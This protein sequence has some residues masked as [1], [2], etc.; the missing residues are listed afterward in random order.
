MDAR[1]VAMELHRDNARLPVAPLEPSPVKPRKRGG[2][3]PQKA[4][5]PHPYTRAQLDSRTHAAKIWDTLSANIVA[6]NGGESEISAVKKTLIDAFVGVAIRM[7]DLN[8][9]GLLGQ[10]L[11]TPRIDA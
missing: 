9:R 10:H 4:T 2:S 1:P 3:H 7:G 5:R 11:T 8:T 6:E